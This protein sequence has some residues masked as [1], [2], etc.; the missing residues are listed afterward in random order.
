MNRSDFRPSNDV[1][2]KEYSDEITDEERAQNDYNELKKRYPEDKKPLTAI[3]DDEK[4]HKG[5]L[6]KLRDKIKMRG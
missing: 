1:K 5:I 3:R 4:E 2:Y 6:Q